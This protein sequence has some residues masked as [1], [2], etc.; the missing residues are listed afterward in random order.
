MAKGI[1]SYKEPVFLFTSSSM[2]QA[3][4]AG[5]YSALGN[6][7]L[8]N[9]Y[10]HAAHSEWIKELGAGR[11]YNFLGRYNDDIW[12]HIPEEKLKEIINNFFKS[13]KIEIKKSKT[14]TKRST[15]D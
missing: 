9:K 1:T 8:A 5:W 6:K 12:R 4:W 15:N 3:A 2:R 10:V 7:E 13:I 14:S 11:R